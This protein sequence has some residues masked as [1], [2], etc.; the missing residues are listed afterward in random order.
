M[1]KPE[2]K[3]GKEVEILHNNLSEL[4]KF[5]NLVILSGIHHRRIYQFIL[6]F[7]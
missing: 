2:T 1:H 5:K 4:I 6:H 3:I 7:S